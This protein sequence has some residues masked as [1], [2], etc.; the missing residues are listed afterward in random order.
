MVP[1]LKA[2]AQ[3]LKYLLKSLEKAFISAIIYFDA[4]SIL[5]D[6]ITEDPHNKD[7]V[8]DA[9]VDMGFN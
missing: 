5:K 7:L 9:L 4:A 8:I 2:I 3:N 6:L 1:L